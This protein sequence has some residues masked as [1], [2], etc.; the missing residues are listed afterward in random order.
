MITKMKEFIKNIWHTIKKLKENKLLKTTSDDLCHIYINNKTF[1]IPLPF[2][3][4]LVEINKDL[5][6]LPSKLS[7]F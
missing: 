3:S 6:I 2:K 7:V 1:N 4:K 5:I